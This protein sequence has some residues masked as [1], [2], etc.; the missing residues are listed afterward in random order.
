MDI[1]HLFISTIKSSF[2][3]NKIVFGDLSLNSKK[4]IQT[5]QQGGKNIV[6]VLV[7]AGGC[8]TRS[9]NKLIQ[10]LRC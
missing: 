9:I 8:I 4:H 7:V 5:V 6:T 3:C 1:L 2:G 10:H